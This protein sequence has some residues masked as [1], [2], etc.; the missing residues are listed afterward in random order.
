MQAVSLKGSGDSFVSDGG[1]K[2]YTNPTHTSHFRTRDFSRLA[3]DLSHHVKSPSA[4]SLALQILH[5]HC[6][7]HMEMTTVTIHNKLR[8][9]AHWLN[10]NC[11]HFLRPIGWRNGLSLERGAHQLQR[12]L[13][14]SCSTGLASGFSRVVDFVGCANVSCA[15]VLVGFVFLSEATDRKPSSALVGGIGRNIG[16]GLDVKPWHW[17]KVKV[18]AALVAM[19]KT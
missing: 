9:S 8:L 5:L 1:C 12:F 6:S 7:F 14:P 2:H 18:H 10:R 4:L 17:S 13:G 3:Q 16:C 19:P 15:G 11:L